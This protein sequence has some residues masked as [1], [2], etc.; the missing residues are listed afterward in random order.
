MND[1]SRARRDRWF[2]KFSISL[3]AT[4]PGG[5]LGWTWFTMLCIIPFGFLV[6]AIRIANRLDP[7]HAG[8]NGDAT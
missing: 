7:T 5:L 8:H 2:G 6:V 4:H 3:G 1:I